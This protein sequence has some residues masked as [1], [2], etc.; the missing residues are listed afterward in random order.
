MNYGMLKQFLE[1]TPTGPTVR[2]DRIQS[3]DAAA[4]AS[5]VSERRR[6]EQDETVKHRISAEVCY[7]TIEKA[8]RTGRLFF[9]QNLL[10]Y[11]VA[12]IA[13]SCSSFRFST[14]IL[15]KSSLLGFFPRTISS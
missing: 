10:A 12:D 13:A 11:L 2:V 4:E 6:P 5:V 8:A 15:I 14:S 7:G 1:T 3:K 9:S